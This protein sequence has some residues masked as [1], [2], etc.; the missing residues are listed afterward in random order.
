MSSSS[1]VAAIVMG[2]TYGYEVQPENDPY[3]SAVLEL[4]GILT[5]GL[6]PEKSAILLAFPFRKLTS[7]P[8]SVAEVSAVAHIPTWF[9][10]ANLQREA[11]HS[12][13]L[14][15]K[16]LN[17]PFEFTKSQIVTNFASH[18]SIAT[19]VTFRQPELPHN[20]WCLIA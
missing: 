15:Q 7:I 1:F 2:I 19:D 10:G 4:N 12:R 11:L 6:T 3:V 9:P 5:K 17:A 16:V 8:S 13:Q 20:L 18:Q 14:A